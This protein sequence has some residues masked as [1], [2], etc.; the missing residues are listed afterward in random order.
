MLNAI[1]YFL[2]IQ[3][4]RSGMVY[5]LVNVNSPGPP[6]PRHTQGI[7]TFEKICCQSPLY[8]SK[9]PCLFI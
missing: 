1:E 6:P 2:N 5:A 7:L 9:V 3:M 8:G 4:V